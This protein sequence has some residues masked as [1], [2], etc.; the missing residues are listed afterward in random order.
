M[1]GVAGEAALGHLS[2]GRTTL[3]IAHRL[4]IVVD[5]D[6]I[7]VLEHGRI[8]EHGCQRQ[9]LARAATT[10]RSGP[11]SRRRWRGEL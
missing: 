9:L 4:S 8:I 1:G 11:A 6:R 5:A 3:I 7:L 10:P 2:A